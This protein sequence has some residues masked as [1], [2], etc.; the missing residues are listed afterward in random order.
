M[1]S[2]GRTR[3]KREKHHC[4]GRR[5]Q[6]RRRWRRRRRGRRVQPLTLSFCR[7]RRRRRRKRRRRRRLERI[8]LARSPLARIEHHRARKGWDGMEER[9][10]EERVKSVS[11]ASALNCAFEKPRGFE[12]SDEGGEGCEHASKA[13]FSRTL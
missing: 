5:R 11:V 10:G 1:A 2:D 3:T 4:Y 8:L 7:A 13:A 12:R 6:G 9:R